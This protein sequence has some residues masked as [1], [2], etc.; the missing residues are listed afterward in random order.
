MTWQF[1]GYVRVPDEPLRRLQLLYTENPRRVSPGLVEVVVSLDIKLEVVQNGRRMTGRFAEKFVGGFVRGIVTEHGIEYTDGPYMKD[2]GPPPGYPLK[3]MFDDKLRHNLSAGGRKVTLLDVPP[4]AIIVRPGDPPHVPWLVI[5]LAVVPVVLFAIYGRGPR[6][7]FYQLMSDFPECEDQRAQWWRLVSYQLVHTSYSHVL[8]NCAMLL[9]FGLPIEVTHGALPL[10]VVHQLGVLGGALVCTIADSYD[11]VVG[12][13]GGVY[14]LFGAHVANVV[15]DWDRLK[16]GFLNRRAR[17][18]GLFVILVTDL[19]SW[20]VTRAHRVSYAAHV[21]GAGVGL[22]LG[23]LVLRRRK[24]RKMS[25]LVKKCKR[26]IFL[27]CLLVFTVF[28]SFSITWYVQVW[29][30]R[31][32]THAW[33]DYGQRKHRPCCIQIYDCGEDPADYSTLT[34]HYHAKEFQLRSTTRTLATCNAL[35]NSR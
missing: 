15:K 1:A 3:P 6:S 29:P 10:F 9:T 19:T 2:E 32:I 11:S 20:Y 21:G 22:I 13:S 18:A 7:F 30:P 17:L 28:L 31:P 8:S 25:V 26:P 27:F 34:C 12:S 23:V 14:A 16:N 5:V 35:K 33:Y 4:S 24:V